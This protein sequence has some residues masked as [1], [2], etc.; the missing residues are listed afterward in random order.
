MASE[1]CWDLFGPAQMHS[2]TFGYVRKRSEA[3]RRFGI[4]CIFSTFFAL[5]PN[6]GEA[7][8]EMCARTAPQISEMCSLKLEN[9]NQFR[10]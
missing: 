2:D 4:F 5:V 6:T 9:N 8:E 1:T 3:F 7:N 10:R